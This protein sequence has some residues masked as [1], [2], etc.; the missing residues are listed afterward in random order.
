M[1]KEMTLLNKAVETGEQRFNYQEVVF[2]EQYDE[3][4]GEIV[5]FISPQI[6]DNDEIIYDGKNP[7][8]VENITSTLNKVNA[9]NQKLRK[10]C[11]IILG[12]YRKCPIAMT[13]KEFKAY[14]E[15]KEMGL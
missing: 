11:S 13:K 8:D 10:N 12:Y 7:E 14:N 4:T 5:K 6:L 3:D 1:K 2:R 9:E 15:L